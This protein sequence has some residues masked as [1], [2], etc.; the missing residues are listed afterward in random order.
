MTPSLL[1]PV[2][3]KYHRGGD[4]NIEGRC[5]ANLCNALKLA[6]FD[7]FRLCYYYTTCYNIDSALRLLE[8]PRLNSNV[9]KF[10]TDRRWVR[11]CGR[12]TRIISECNLYKFTRLSDLNS[13]SEAVSIVEKWYYFGRY[14]AFLFLETYFAAVK[15]NWKDD[16]VFAWE[17]EENYTL[18]AKSLINESDSL[19]LN[20]L[21]AELKEVPTDKNNSNSLAIETGLCGFWKILKGTRYDGFYKDRML[22]EAKTSGFRDL[23]LSCANE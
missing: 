3:V 9:L 4:A 7:R 19:S 18:G 12:F 11:Y 15:P 5:L 1:F 14:A 21:L 22:N 8:N 6:N 23:I 2:F 20:T 17:P 13:I 16:V 10:R